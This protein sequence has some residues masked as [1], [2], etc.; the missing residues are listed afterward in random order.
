M[1]PNQ[2]IQNKEKVLVNINELLFSLK[3]YYQICNR[4]LISNEKIT[5]NIGIT[6]D[7]NPFYLSKLKSKFIIIYTK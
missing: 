1:N 5:P 4:N 3:K 6:N 2:L 7:M